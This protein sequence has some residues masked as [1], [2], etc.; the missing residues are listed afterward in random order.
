VSAYKEAK[1]VT[2]AIFQGVHLWQVLRLDDERAVDFL[3]D[4][5]YGYPITQNAPQACRLSRAAWRPGL[6]S[7]NDRR[8]P[9][10]ERE[11]QESMVMLN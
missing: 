8:Y 5:P 3:I 9:R 2:P 7:E 6:S 4:L 1:S 11:K 10:T